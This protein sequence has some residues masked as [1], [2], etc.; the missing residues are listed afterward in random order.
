VVDAAVDDGVGA[1]E[2]GVGIDWR[3]VGN[4]P[5]QSRKG[6]AELFVGVVADGDNEVIV[7]EDVVERLGAVAVDAESVALGNGYSARVDAWAGMGSGGGGWSVAQLAAASWE[8]AEFAVQ[9]N[10]TRGPAGRLLGMR[11]EMAAAQKVG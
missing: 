5:V 9:T 3:R 6:V 7:V 8:R 4:R 11:P 10:S 2:G 1:L